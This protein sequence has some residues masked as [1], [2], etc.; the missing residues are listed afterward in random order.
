MKDQI[1]KPEQYLNNLADIQLKKGELTKISL[2][3]DRIQGRVLEVKEDT[4]EIEGYG[5]VPLDENFKVYKTYGE[6]KSR[7]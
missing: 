6:F 1:E 2:K 7:R 5:E 4:I 3:K